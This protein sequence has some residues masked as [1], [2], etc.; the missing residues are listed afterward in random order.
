MTREFERVT[1]RE[2]EMR[3][4]ME[5]TERDTRKDEKRGRDERQGRSKREKCK[6]CNC[7]NFCGPDIFELIASVR[8][9]LLYI[10][11]IGFEF[12]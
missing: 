1:R 11:G 2:R 8:Y 9:F 4:E 5:E 10:T 7:R 12:L 3:R 6:I